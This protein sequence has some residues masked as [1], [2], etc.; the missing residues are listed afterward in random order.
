VEF[1]ASTGHS[2]LMT[3]VAA[4]EERYQLHVMLHHVN[5]APWRRLLVRPDMTIDHLHRLIQLSMGWAEETWHEFRIHGTVHF[6]RRLGYGG[7]DPSG[8]A[9]KTLASFCLIPGERFGYNYGGWRC[10]LRLEKV[11]VVDHPR[12]SPACTGGKWG[13]PPEHCGD[14]WSY[15]THRQRIRCPSEAIDLFA[16]LIE[17]PLED[18]GCFRER[19]KSI[20]AWSRWMHFDRRQ[21]Y[22]RLRSASLAWDEGLDDVF[23]AADGN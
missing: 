10:Q 8:T 20:A 12:A 22:T 11:V 14:G 19:A 7:S 9:D 5:P 21:L 18:A 15:M 23:S 6:G 3:K 17:E 1:G 16:A 2:G 13:T 4:A